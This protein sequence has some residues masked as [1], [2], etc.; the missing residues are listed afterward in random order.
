MKVI[1]LAGKSKRPPRTSRCRSSAC[2][3]SRCDRDR[4]GWVPDLLFPTVKPEH[5]GSIDVELTLDAAKLG[6]GRY[7]EMLKLLLNTGRYEKG[8]KDFQLVTTVNLQ[9]G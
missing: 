2:V 6:E 8:D 9:D 1:I 3:L 5:L 7:A 4:R